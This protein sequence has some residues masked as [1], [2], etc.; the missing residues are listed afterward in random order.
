MSER[1][2]RR[3]L[4]DDGDR[5]ASGT[6][7]RSKKPPT[8]MPPLPLR[9][10]LLLAGT[11]AGSIL[12]LPRALA[13]LPPADGPMPAPPFPDDRPFSFGFIGDTPYSRLEANALA[14]V[15]EA[16]AAEPL[17]LVVHV[18]D[19]KSSLE[20]CDDDL[21]GERIALLDRCPHP[22]VLTPGDNEW[23][24]CSRLRAPWQP[25]MRLDRLD[26]LRRHAFG[27]AHSLGRRRMAVQQQ[28]PYRPHPQELDGE[29]PTLPENL[30]WRIGSLQFCTLH[31]VG[32]DNGRSKTPELEE[33]WLR[34]Q[35]ANGDWLN[36]TVQLAVADK[37]KGLVIALH[38][39]M[40]FEAD[41]A[42]G[43]ARMRNLVVAAAAAFNGPVLLLHGDTHHFR[44]DRL[45]LRSHGLANFRRVECFGSPFSSSWV[46]IRWDPTLARPG[47]GEASDPFQV[48]VRSLP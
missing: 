2:R 11:A 15:F 47:A 30:R 21:L 24:D 18:G 36:R 14:S 9:R 39:N 31:V 1:D 28:G 45:L 7:L 8:P 25:D 10:R 35:Q 41:R 3:R 22:L 34:R 26:W 37:A 46:Q 40:R 6:S 17:E 32:S 44:S 33:A 27:D 23:T 13:E 12:V 38:A 19:I 42:D 48:S 20:G 4:P 43:W 16:M 29:P 5:R